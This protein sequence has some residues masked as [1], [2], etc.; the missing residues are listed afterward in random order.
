M[1]II[2]DADP[3]LLISLSIL[4][5]EGVCL[6]KR[7]NNLKKTG[8]LT[9][10]M[11]NTDRIFVNVYNDCS[12][13]SEF[14][15]NFHMIDIKPKHLFVDLN[16]AKK[17][18]VFPIISLLASL[19]QV[20]EIKIFCVFNS[21]GNYFDIWSAYGRFFDCIFVVSNRMVNLIRCE[22]GKISASLLGD[23]YENL[24]KFIL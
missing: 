12:D 19:S 10:R 14:L 24:S 15:G 21:H 4:C 2:L 23:V 18:E 5:E 1:K 20:A 7:S 9:P 8:F 13:L 3:H 6:L 11:G 17:K 16:V 22:V